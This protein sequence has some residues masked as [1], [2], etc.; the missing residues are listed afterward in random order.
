MYMAR[1]IMVSNKCYEELKKR[2]GDN[3]SFSDVII[4]GLTKAPKTGEGLRKFLGVLK[5]DKEY[6]EIMAKSKKM[7]AEWKEKA[8]EYA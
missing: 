7:W 6:D 8:K 2:K 1:T 4:E 3:K 5:D